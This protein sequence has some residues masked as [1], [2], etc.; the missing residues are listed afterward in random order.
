[1]TLY[2]Q[3]NKSTQLGRTTLKELK[4]T[5]YE[6]DSSANAV[7]LYEHGNFY[8]DPANN[9]N[10]R[11]D[12]Y[13]RIK[14]INKNAFD[15]ATINLVTYKKENIKNVRAKTYNISSSGAMIIDDLQEKD[16]FT[17]EITKNYTQITFTLPNIK[18]GS[19][20]EYSYS[21][22]SPYIKIEDWKFQ[23]EIP[24]MKSDFD[25]S[26]PGYY[27][28]KI[29]L[30]GFK[31]LDKEESTIKKNCLNNS[32]G[33][34]SCAIISYG[35]S[36]IPAFKEESYMT[37]KKNFESK[38]VFDLKSVIN[39]NG[40][41]NYTT[42][43]KAAEHTL[44]KYFLDN[45]TSR[46]GF[47][48][49][50]LPENIFVIGN[51][52]ERAKKVYKYI[53]NYYTWN[54]WYWNGNA[55][56][57]IRAAFQEKSGSVLDIN[58]ALFNALKAAEIETY[59]VMLSTRSNGLPTK[60]YPVTND[61][62][63]VLVKAIID[64]KE[65]FLD[66]TNKFTPFGQVPE[67]CLNGEARVIDFD[68]V[69]YWQEITQ[70]KKTNSTIK[71][72]LKLNK[73]YEFGG[74]IKITTTGYSALNKRETIALLSKEAY[75][76]SLE[77]NNESLLIDAYN[78]ENLDNPDKTFIENFKARI[79]SDPLNADT[80]KITINP[81]VMGRTKE[82]PFKLKE[83]N[84]PVDIGYPKKTTS[85]ISIYV[86]E[87][88]SVSRLPKSMAIKLPNNDG[89]Y[90]LDVKHEGETVTIYSKL[91]FN[92]SVFSSRE[93]HYLKEFYKQI[94]EAESVFI[95]FTLQN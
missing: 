81:F 67:R 77:G 88:Y 55:E 31:N 44:K 16:I 43:W 54:E 2:S 71:V 30:V 65:Y 4:M 11:T 52:L 38:L 83:R 40:K 84:Y 68:K 14:I 47:F 50:N 13:F 80:K 93:Y 92:K 25:A 66:A 1:M 59:I 94:I 87:G 27:T 79:E 53:Q 24:K 91:Q 58:L 89:L 12:F 95:E 75:L 5:V 90:I 61:F 57:Q 17:K 72:L 76:E 63:Y 23:S 64:G 9:H 51:S 21:V 49:R 60:L 82:N 46:K 70:I 35:M 48:H 18:E 10:L 56:T 7:V 41:T 78:N 32:I 62:N 85:L 69:G 36:N 28:Y 73:D 42:T 29:R 6:N 19:V 26:L 20:I 15:L 34:F 39:L 33:Q 74:Q 8:K 22:I 45:Q 86:P 37:S 3:K